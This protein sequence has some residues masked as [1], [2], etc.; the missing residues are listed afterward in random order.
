MQVDI[1]QIYI[2]LWITVAVINYI[3]IES[4]LNRTSL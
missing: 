3:I 1:T 2:K 4:S